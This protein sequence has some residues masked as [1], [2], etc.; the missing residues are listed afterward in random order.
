MR[1]CWFACSCCCLLSNVVVCCLMCFEFRSVVAVSR[2]PFF[3]YRSFFVACCLLFA[4]CS[5]VLFV[6]RCLWFA[7][8]CVLFVVCCLL[9]F[10][11]RVLQ[12]ICRERFAVRCLLRVVCWFAFTVRCLCLAGHGG[13]LFV[14]CCKM[15]V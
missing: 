6:E 14:A 12:A 5:G 1:V 3:V 11:C 15:I 2:L 8:C 4:G 7:V 10:V 9:L 13:L